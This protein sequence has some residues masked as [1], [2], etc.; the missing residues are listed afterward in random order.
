MGKRNTSALWR[1]PITGI[2]LGTAKKIRTS[3]RGETWGEVVADRGRVAIRTDRLVQS[4][5]RP[6]RLEQIA[7]GTPL[8]SWN[9]ADDVVFQ[10]G[11]VNLVAIGGF[12][13]DRSAVVTLS[14]PTTDRSAPP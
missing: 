7:F 9:R 14:P 6:G 1:A 5:G 2:R 11:P 10:E 3:R 12:T 13:Q 4:G 8:G